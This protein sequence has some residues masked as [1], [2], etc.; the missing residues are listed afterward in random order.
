[1]AQGQGTWNRFDTAVRASTGRIHGLTGFFVA[2]L[3][4]GVTV[5]VLWSLVVGIGERQMLIQIPWGPQLGI[6]LSQSSG[7]EQQAERPS[8][9]DQ[10][11]LPELEQIRMKQMMPMFSPLQMGSGVCV[12]GAFGGIKV[13]P[14]GRRRG[15]RKP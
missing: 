14:P 3:T 1:M 4:L 9:D 8:P 12:Y 11:P 2:L 5:T 13:Y 7:D 15:R 6:S 10:Q